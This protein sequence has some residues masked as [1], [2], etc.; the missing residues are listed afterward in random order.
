MSP[1]DLARELQDL[2][3]FSP[4]PADPKLLLER[5]T[6]IADLQQE[7]AELRQSADSLKE[8]LASLS[9][10]LDREK[11]KLA[12][13]QITHDS[14]E[15]Q[16]QADLA[17]LDY[18]RRLWSSNLISDRAAKRSRYAQSVYWIC[19]ALMSV[20]LAFASVWIGAKYW[21]YSHDE[22]LQMLQEAT[23]RNAQATAS[24]D[25]ARRIF[26][27]ATRLQ[28]QSRHPKT[29]TA[30]DANTASPDPN[31]T[32]TKDKQEHD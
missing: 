26:A 23:Q 24:L 7:N 11:K 17:E 13:L 30:R 21:T 6:R 19:L 20:S 3:R 18:N 14:L 27:Q 5:D 9:G 12:Q 4:P 8:K 29:S 15:R 16:N 1:D 10:D 31:G 28:R 25:Q 22:H 32:A 2:Q